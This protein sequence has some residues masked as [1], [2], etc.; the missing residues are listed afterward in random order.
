M[1][2]RSA[3]VIENAH[4]DGESPEK[5]LKYVQEAEEILD[6][7]KEF[8]AHEEVSRKYHDKRGLMRYYKN[9]LQA[10][11]EESR[12]IDAA[13]KQ[14][15]PWKLKGINA[16]WGNRL[17]EWTLSVG[18]EKGVLKSKWSNKWTEWTFSLP[19]GK[20]EMAARWGNKWTEWKYSA[21]GVAISVE[22]RFSNKLDQWVVSDDKG[23]K[24]VVE[25]RFSNKWTDWKIKGPKGI[26][27]IST[28]WSNKISEWVIEDYMPGESVH[29][30]MAAIFPCL[31]VAC[32]IIQ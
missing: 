2:F 8:H 25:A 31:M 15:D 20:G 27:K 4:A 6:K 3:R 5:I 28:R 7:T 1:L 9:S 29:L 16:R 23:N 10:K 19:Q 21:D 11:D 26:I 12:I 22:T 32:D 24:I 18:E 17:D 13:K 14:N 30:K